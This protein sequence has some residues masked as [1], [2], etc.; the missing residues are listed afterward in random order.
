MNKNRICPIC[1]NEVY[2]YLDEWGRTPWHLY[3]DNCEINI[4]TTS[5]KKAVNLIQKYPFPK[6]WIEYYV[7]CINGDFIKSK[8][9]V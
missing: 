8:T 6:T 4:G 1:H 3:C 7:G 2:F 5:K 9:G